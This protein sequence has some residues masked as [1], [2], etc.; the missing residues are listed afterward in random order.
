M[1]IGSVLAATAQQGVAMYSFHC[2]HTSATT[3]CHCAHTVLAS[4]V[5]L[6]KCLKRPV[7]AVSFSTMTAGAHVLEPVASTSR[8]LLSLW[9][10]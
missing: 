3:C 1:C 2:V 5:V 8:L 9:Q 7:A 10:W 4:R 6:Q